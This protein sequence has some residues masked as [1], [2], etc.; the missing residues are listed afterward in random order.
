M[1]LDEKALAKGQHYATITCDLVDGHVIDMAPKRTGE[2]VVRCL[3]RFSLDDLAGIKAVA[4]DMWQP[5]IRVASL[6][7]P[8]EETNIVF[9]R[10]HIVAHMNDAVDQ[11]RRREN[12]ELRALG[13]QQAPLALRRRESPRGILPLVLRLATS[14]T[15]DSGHRD[16]FDRPIVIGQIGIVIAQSERSDDPLGGGSSWAVRPPAFFGTVPSV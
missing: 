14:H 15:A 1:G 7:L 8:Q 13:I 10:Y 2:S 5:F 4:M 6:L 16:R 11:V 3:V 12:R 9:D